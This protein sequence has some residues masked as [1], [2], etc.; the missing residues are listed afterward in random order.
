MSSPDLDEPKGDGFEIAVDAD[1]LRQVKVFIEV[2]PDELKHEPEEF[3]FRVRE[4]TQGETAE[5]A[6]ARA[7]FHGYNRNP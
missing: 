4:V 2:P 1:K 6:E 5:T 7:I 3:D